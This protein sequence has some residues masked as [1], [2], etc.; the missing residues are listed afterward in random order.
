ME[1]SLAEEHAYYFIPQISL[2]TARDRIE[3]KKSSCVFLGL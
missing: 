2:N 3:K 1:I